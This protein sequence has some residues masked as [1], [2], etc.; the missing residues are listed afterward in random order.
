[1]NRGTDP[2]RAE[3]DRLTDPML[4]KAEKAR[5]IAQEAERYSMHLDALGPEHE[6]ATVAI[7]LNGPTWRV[8]IEG[9]PQNKMPGGLSL[10]HFILTLTED[11]AT[12]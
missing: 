11:P 4:S 8:T 2:V 10:R 12:E 5:A 9:Q 1:M 6:H 7:D 3:Y